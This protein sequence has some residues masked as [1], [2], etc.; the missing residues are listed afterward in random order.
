MLDVSA[1]EKMT[2]IVAD[3]QANAHTIA[4]LTDSYPDMTIEDGYAVQDALLARWE[5]QGRVLVGLKAGL[6][7]KA[8]MDQMGV[9]EPSFGMLMGDT[10]D[11]DGGIVPTDRL[12]HPRVEAEIAFVTKAE[13]AGPEVSI[14]DVLAATDFVQPAIEII[15]SR[16]EKF[17]FDLVS[18]IADN[19]SSAR[20]VMG[21]RPRRPQDVDLRTIG[22]VLEKN[23]EVVGMASSGA[24]LGHPARSMQMLVAWLHGR[25]RTLPAGSIVLTGGATE[26]V[27]VASGDAIVA[28]YQGMGSISVRIG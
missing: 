26:A 10:V 15:D 16:F 17:K 2:G 4:K 14:E 13:L 28:R 22:M 1:I 8:K 23:G 21:G 25:G 19:G 9:T 6:T 27:A 20:F 5:D 11:P 24:V 12:I 7:S 18:V 3:A